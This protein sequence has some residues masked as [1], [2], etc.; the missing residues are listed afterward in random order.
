M[1]LSFTRELDAEAG[2]VVSALFSLLFSSS[3]FSELNNQVCER[4]LSSWRLS[5]PGI[6]E[7]SILRLA[8]TTLNVIN[9]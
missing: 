3:L 8:T 1:F 7:D 2:Y 9:N 5:L 4:T 6:Y